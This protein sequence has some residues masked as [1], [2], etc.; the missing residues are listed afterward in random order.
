MFSLF[1]S[2]ENSAVEIVKPGS[3]L[4]KRMGELIKVRQKR[5]DDLGDSHGDIDMRLVDRVIEVLDPLL[6]PER[7]SAEDSWF[8]NMDYYGNGVRHLEL[9]PSKFPMSVIPDL[10][11]LLVG[12]H[13]P[14]TILCWAPL[15]EKAPAEH[16][17][18]LAIFSDKVLLTAKLA[19]ANTLVDT[20]RGADV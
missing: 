13:E 2:R 1:A 10:Q 11:S 9:K 20:D 3:G 6:G 14:F 16:E 4:I 8:H 7:E 5:L 17:Q 12:E 19:A 18:G 15:S